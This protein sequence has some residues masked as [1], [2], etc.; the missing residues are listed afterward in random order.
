MPSDTYQLTKNP[1]ALCEI[2]DTHLQREEDRLSYRWIMLNLAWHYLNGA[3]RFDVFDPTRNKMTAHYL[4]EEGDM[5]FQCQEMMS[6][7]DRTSGQISNMDVRASINRAGSSLQSIRDRSISQVMMDAVSSE[8]VIEKA[9]SQFA[10][11]F[12]ALGCCGITG[13]LEDHPTI[14]LTGD[15]E[16]I[17]PR[18]LFPFPSLGNDYT[19]VRGM[20]RRRVV[21]LKWLEDK[22]GKRIKANRDKMYWWA[23][24]PGSIPSQEHDGDGSGG[25]GGSFEYTSNAS[26]TTGN[27]APPQEY[28]TGLVRI[29]ELWMTG[30][31]D[32]CTRYVVYSGQYV[33]ED[34]DLS[35]TESYCPIGMA[36]FIENGSFHGLGLFDL[37][38]SINRQLELLLKSLF[39][40]IRDVDRYGVV[41]MPQGQFNDRALLRDVGRGLR[42]LPWEADPI[43]PGFKPFQIQPATLGEVPGKTAAFAKEL[44]QSISPWQDLLREKGR[45][46]S[47]AG[48]GFLD[49][50]IRGLMTTSTAAVDR[51][52]SAAHRNILRKV[53][54]EVTQTQRALPINHLT[55]DLAGAVIDPEK[56]TVTFQDN[57]LP[58]LSHLTVTIK[59]ASPKSEVVRKQEA[60][61]LFGIE[62]LNDP[63]RFILHA[64]EN[65]LDFAMDMEEE[66]AAYETIVRNI[67]LL[68]GNG[69]EP[70]EIVMTPST[71]MPE[72]QLRILNRFMS[73]L[74]M[75]VASANVIDAFI[76]LQQFLMN[77]LGLVLP[78]AV[79]NP[80]D[81]ALLQE[82]M[83]QMEG[84]GQP[85][86][87]GAM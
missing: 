65:G 60:V 74:P 55:L 71:S 58:K 5:E 19:K 63:Q 64:I 47:A 32:L 76:N 43:D 73:S 3:R 45:V 30:H 51:A 36:R 24:Q 14:G 18:E 48:L 27:A 66:R 46:D 86:L 7:I 6:A 37:L 20:I 67:L 23:A 13:H 39:N 4:D 75:Q 28:E 15:Y 50:K 33:L 10:H 34:I 59:S 85:Q 44:M 79:P 25:H 35:T 22:Y 53:A 26:N 56:D 42:V 52:W 12:T 54:D 2:L 29:Q 11:L 40:N 62:G 9:Q 49:E 78:A 81:M 8:E 72:F 70:G 68:Y 69:E 87:E 17:H 41:V 38:F 16:V 82:P 84:E 1:K 31:R 21:P 57:P 80:D 61:Q 77:S 83:E